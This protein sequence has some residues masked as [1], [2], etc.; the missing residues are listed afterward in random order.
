MVMRVEC[1]LQRVSICETNTN[2]AILKQVR[3][4]ILLQPSHTNMFLAY[5][6]GLRKISK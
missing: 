4:H 6:A 2:T 1:I 3:I 5:S